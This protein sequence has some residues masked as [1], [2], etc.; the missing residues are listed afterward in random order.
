MSQEVVPSRLFILKEVQYSVKKGT[1]FQNVLQKHTRRVFKR[2]VSYHTPSVWVTKEH[3]E[4]EKV[5]PGGGWFK[6]EEETLLNVIEYTRSEGPYKE[7]QRKRSM[8]KGWRM[9]EIEPGQSDRRR[10][11]SV[12]RHPKLFIPYKGNLN[13]HQRHSGLISKRAPI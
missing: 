1:P 5:R 11:Q 3:Q 8:T 2:K 7:T 6:D 13:S 9:K 12:T 10:S 4:Q